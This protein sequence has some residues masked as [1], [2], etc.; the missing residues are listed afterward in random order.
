MEKAQK[1]IEFA[2]CIGNMPKV[3]TDK[4]AAELQ[5][6]GVTALEPGRFGIQNRDTATFVKETNIIYSHDIKI[7][8]VHG[9]F[10]QDDISNVNE[11]ARLDALKLNIKCLEN[12]SAAGIECM[13]IHS[14]AIL[15]PHEKKLKMEQLRKSLDC[16]VKEAEKYK[17][18]L[19]LE[20]LLMDYI[21]SDPVELLNIVQSYNSYYLGTCFDT[22]HANQTPSGAEKTFDTIKDTIINFHLND[23]DKFSDRHL[24]PPYGTVNW[25]S[26]LNKIKKLN[27]SRPVSIEAD[28]WDKNTWK[29]M[30]TEVYA[31][32]NNE[33]LTTNINGN[34]VYVICPDCKHYCHKTSSGYKCMCDGKT[35]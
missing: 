17:V 22:G 13:V 18:R 19:A 2:I 1:S 28:P 11:E 10:N 4:W 21:G 23:N 20:N 33:L 16:L 7:H 26:I 8:T 3:V 6:N 31:L 34:E 15:Q 24:Q 12:A 35:Y 32:A 25:K 27:F 9:P 29:Q 5:H 30:L 14:S